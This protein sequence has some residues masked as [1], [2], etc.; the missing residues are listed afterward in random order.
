MPESVTSLCNKARHSYF[1]FHGQRDRET[2]TNLANR[3]GLEYDALVKCV[4]AAG[5]RPS[6]EIYV[7]RWKRYVQPCAPVRIVAFPELYFMVACG[8]SDEDNIE[9]ADIWR[10]GVSLDAETA[11]LLAS[12]ARAEIE[13]VLMWQYGKQLQFACGCSTQLHEAYPCTRHGRAEAIRMRDDLIEQR[14]DE[15]QQ[16][17]LKKI[18]A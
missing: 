18:A 6:K 7:P 11:S 17:F 10:D 14:R 15:W 3:L 8:A 5:S 12:A 9:A 13:A 16:R 4:P 1:E 2:Y